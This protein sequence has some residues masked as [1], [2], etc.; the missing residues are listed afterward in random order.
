M[1]GI[2]NDLFVASLQ[3]GLLAAALDAFTGSATSPWR[4][5]GID[6]LVNMAVALGC[7]AVFVTRRGHDTDSRAR[8]VPG[9]IAAVLTLMGLGYLTIV[10]ATRIVTEA[11]PAADPAVVAVIRTAILSVTAVALALACRRSRLRELAWLVYPLLGLGCLTLLLEDL[12]QGTPITLFVA[13]GLFGAAMILAPRLVS[14]GRRVRRKRG[15]PRPDGNG[16]RRGRD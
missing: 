6:G 7:F 11:P 16:R 15:R 3:T 5:L 9:V 10:L 1:V 13:F 4:V 12:R 8:R 2:C 14:A